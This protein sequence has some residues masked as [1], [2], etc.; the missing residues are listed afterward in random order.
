MVSVCN[1][2]SPKSIKS[3]QTACEAN[4]ECIRKGML[5]SDLGVFMEVLELSL[6]EITAI[7]ILGSIFLFGLHS[8]QLGW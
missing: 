7:T 8:R 4:Y 2:R 3:E 6:K 5:T 1:K